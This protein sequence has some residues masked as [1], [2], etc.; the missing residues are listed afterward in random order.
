[1]E[2]SHAWWVLLSLW[3]CGGH[4]QSHG[5]HRPFRGGVIHEATEKCV[6]VS[7]VLV[8][9]S[10]RVLC[11][12]DPGGSGVAEVPGVMIVRV[13]TSEITWQVVLRRPSHDVLLYKVLYC[14][15]KPFDKHW[16]GRY[17]TRC[18]GRAR[19]SPRDVVETC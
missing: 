1:M 3:R 12:L 10:R 6:L 16:A 7:G 17:C 5:C 9:D 2:A 13:P 4:S 19:F 8:R 14:D 11:V 15:H 18:G